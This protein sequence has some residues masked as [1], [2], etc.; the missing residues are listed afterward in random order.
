MGCDGVF[1]VFSNQELVEKINKSLKKDL[2]LKSCL[3]DLLD[4]ICAPDTSSD[5]LII[6]FFFN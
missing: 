5:F 6:L 3:N 2:D 1:E 4:E